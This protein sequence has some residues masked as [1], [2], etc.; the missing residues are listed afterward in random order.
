MKIAIGCDHAGYEFKEKVKEILIGWNHDV[1]DFGTY[2]KK[3]VDYPDFG[4][5]VALAVTESKVDYGI[6][7]CWTGNGM[8][9]A[10]NKIRGVR[11]GLALNPEMAMLTRAHNDANVLTLSQKYTPEE[12]LKEILKN[13]FET[14]FEGG[15]HL[16]RVNKIRAAEEGLSSE[17]S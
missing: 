4:L 7:I 11:A 3:S 5:K 10:T 13:F 9:I 15:R 14:P 6:A 16:P 2:S 12:Q 8:T 17:K 1:T